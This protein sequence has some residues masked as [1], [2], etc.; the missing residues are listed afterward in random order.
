[1]PGYV[2]RDGQPIPD[3]EMQEQQPGLQVAPSSTD[4]T[5]VSTSTSSAMN[6]PASSTTDSDHPT[7]SHALANADHNEKGAAQVNEHDMVK[8][9]GWNEHPKEIPGLVG[10][11]DN[12]DLWALV[13]RFNKQMYHVKATKEPLLAGL[14]LNIADEDE[15]SPDK[16]R[17]N[18]ERLYMT[19]IIGLMGFG[20]HIARLRSWR[21]PRRTGAF[22]AVSRPNK[23][24]PSMR[25]SY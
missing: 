19:V 10:G 5:R 23:C 4:M 15:F 22:A 25:S 9:L 18:V 2:F 24:T 11:L 1:M 21:E 12:D 16:L 13:R 6:T 20:K 7:D 8:N 17:A 3:S 14:D